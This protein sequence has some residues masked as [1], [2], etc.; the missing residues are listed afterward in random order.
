MNS[1]SRERKNTL[2]YL[3]L[4]GVNDTLKKRVS[5]SESLRVTKEGK[6]TFSTI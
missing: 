5:R 1:L 2:R 3:N 4:F 6:I